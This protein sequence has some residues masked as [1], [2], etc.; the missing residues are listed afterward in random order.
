[1]SNHNP[2]IFAQRGCMPASLRLENR[3][4]YAGT[5]GCGRSLPRSEVP[6][7][8]VLSLTA[9]DEFGRGVDFSRGRVKSAAVPGYGKL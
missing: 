4:L 7:H 6:T 3:Y 9:V 1:M 8:E 5:G 2:V